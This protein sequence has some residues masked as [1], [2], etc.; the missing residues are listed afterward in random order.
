MPSDTDSDM[1]S[2]A[3]T[4]STR[5]PLSTPGTTP[6]PSHLPTPRNSSPPPIPPAEPDPSTVGRERRVRKSINYTEPKLNTYALG[7]LHSSH[8]GLITLL[9]PQKDAQTRSH[10]A[11]VEADTLWLSIPVRGEPTSLPR[12]YHHGHRTTAQVA[13]SPTRR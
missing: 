1:P 10:A 11:F 9:D 4:S 12:R 3:L 7:F 5:P 6:A 13:P 2:S 8:C